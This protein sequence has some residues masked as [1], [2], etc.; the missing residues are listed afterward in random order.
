LFGGQWTGFALGR[1]PPRL[2]PVCALWP[3]GLGEIRDVI[4]R[5]NLRRFLVAL[6]C[7]LLVGVL[8]TM[9]W[10]G[11][12]LLGLRYAF[13]LWLMLLLFQPAALIFK[14]SQGTNDTSSG[15][16][17]ALAITGMILLTVAAVVGAGW[18]V[19]MSAAWWWQAVGFASLGLVSFGF[20]AIYRGLYCRHRF[21]LLAKAREQG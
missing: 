13:A 16:L 21:D 20:E 14:Y 17:N 3:I 7:W 11:A 1:I 15:C 2:V 6:P 10:D 19:L 12:L 8:G 5:V 9:I 18:A 4:L